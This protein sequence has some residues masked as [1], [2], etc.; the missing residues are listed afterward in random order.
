M[1]LAA[2]LH[3]LHESIEGVAFFL[4][5]VGPPG[6]EL[7]VAVGVAVTGSEEVFELAANEGIGISLH[8]EP[9]VAV[10][11]PRQQ[12]ESFGLLLQGADHNRRASIGLGR[13]RLNAGLLL[14]PHPNGR[15]Q[16]R[17]GAFRSGRGELIDSGDRG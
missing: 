14:Q 10:I 16:P 3:P 2:L 15:V 1:Q 13:C 6:H 12:G 8:V 4:L 9:D 11:R 17:N 5:V 7:A